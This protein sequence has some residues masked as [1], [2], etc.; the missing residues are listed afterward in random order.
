MLMS[1]Q[2]LITASSKNKHHATR[3]SAVYAGL[4]TEFLLILP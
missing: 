2:K 3:M 1:I 4:V